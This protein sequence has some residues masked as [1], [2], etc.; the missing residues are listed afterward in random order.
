MQARDST[1]ILDFGRRRQAPDVVDA[2]AVAHPIDQG[3]QA[4]G[5]VGVSD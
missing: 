5:R 2:P 1:K 3:Y 4:D